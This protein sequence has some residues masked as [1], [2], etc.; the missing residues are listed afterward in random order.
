MGQGQT[1]SAC[2]S[3]RRCVDGMTDLRVNMKTLFLVLMLAGSFAAQAQKPLSATLTNP[4]S[5]TAKFD[6]KQKIPMLKSCLMSNGKPRPYA[7]EFAL[8]EIEVV[9]KNGVTLGKLTPGNTNLTLPKSKASSDVDAPDGKSAAL[10]YLFKLRY[11][12]VHKPAFPTAQYVISTATVDMPSTPSEL[13]ELHTFTDVPGKLPGA[14]QEYAFIVTLPYPTTG[15]PALIVP[16]RYIQIANPVTF[17]KFLS[18]MNKLSDRA[19]TAMSLYF[20][21]DFKQ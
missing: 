14:I 10:G 5:L 19:E 4:G 7:C 12:R 20:G 9:G 11:R 16:I 6:P 17:G 21:V 8:I 13:K 2:Q 1:F 15:S 18:P 3:Q